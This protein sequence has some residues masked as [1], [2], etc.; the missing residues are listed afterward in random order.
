MVKTSGPGP[1]RVV[2]QQLQQLQQQKT[3]QQKEKE[4]VKTEKGEKLSSADQAR[5]ASQAGFHRQ[6]KIPRKGFDVGDGSG[7]QYS[8]P[9]DDLDG[10]AW[11]QERLAS[12]QGS[13]S[14]ASSQFGNFAKAGE[15]AGSLGAAVVGSSFLPND[16]DLEEMEDI[17]KRKPPKPMPMLDEVSNSVS[18]L[19]GIEL[20]DEVPVGHKVLAAGLVVAGETDSVKV[21]KGKLGEQELAGGLQKVTKRGNQAV[22][23]AQR[24]NKGVN[25]KLNVQRTFMFRR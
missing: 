1:G 15:A 6:K 23:E 24:M 19:F 16:E 18:A 22:G 5:I 12:A 11:S 20:S 9:Q 2:P 13:L 25:E 4:K 8:L 17:A 10:E 7:Q 14:L 3:L 21:D